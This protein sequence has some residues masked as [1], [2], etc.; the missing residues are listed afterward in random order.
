M[1]QQWNTKRYVSVATVIDAKI[2]DLLGPCGGHIWRTEAQASLE[3]QRRA[4][5]APKGSSGRTFFSK[6][7]SPERSYAAALRQDMQH[8]QPQAPQIYGK[9]WRTPC[10]SICHIRKF[11]EEV[12]QYR[13]PVRLKMTR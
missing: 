9:S 4:Q 13:L 11:R 12:C 3:L 1:T 2:E 5:R 10:S 7:A 6:F 8:Q